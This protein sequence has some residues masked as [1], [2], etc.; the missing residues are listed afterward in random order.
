MKTA[1]ICNGNI[2][3]YEYVIEIIKK[4]DYVICADGGTRHAFKM[5]IIPDLI[6]GDFDSSDNEYTEYFENKGVKVEKYP[7]EKDKTDSHI[8]VL[9][10]MDFSKE[11]VLI[12]ATGS[13]VDHSL[14]NISLLKLGIDRGIK[15]YIADKQ[16][17]IY[18]INDEISIKGHLGEFF[19]LFSLSE[20]VEGISIS[21]A[22]YTLE[23]QTI[24][25]GDTLGI[26][27]EFKDD[28]VKIKIKKGYLLVIK[29]QD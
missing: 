9:K 19:S 1:I 8:C 16:N 7:I 20:K 5:G 4:T 13:R 12:G 10:A 3:D 17:E 21:G 25:M 2:T 24:Q 11:I 15:I 27:N 29:S 26:S 18:L 14:A 23:N 28:I 6:I 22:K